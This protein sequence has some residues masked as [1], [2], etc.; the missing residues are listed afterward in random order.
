[1]RLAFTIAIG[2]SVQIDLVDTTIG[3]ASHITVLAGEKNQP[4]NGYADIITA[5]ETDYKDVNLT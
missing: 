3:S 1:M 5:L 2:I 4:I